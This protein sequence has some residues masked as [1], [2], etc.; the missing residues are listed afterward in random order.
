MFCP[1]NIPWCFG[2]KATIKFNN[3]ELSFI[4]INEINSGIY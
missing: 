1:D 2:T 4:R 3:A